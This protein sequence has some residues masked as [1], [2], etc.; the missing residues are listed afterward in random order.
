MNSGLSPR[1][2]LIVD[3]VCNF[4]SGRQKWSKGMWPMLDR[5]VCFLLRFS[6]VCGGSWQ[7]AASTLQK[8]SGYLAS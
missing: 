2:D 1:V 6:R 4:M 7:F 8:I 5:R 3:F